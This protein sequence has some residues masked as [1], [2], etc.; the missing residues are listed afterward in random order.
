MRF[1]DVISLVVSVSIPLNDAMPDFSLLISTCRD[2]CPYFRD[3]ATVA[4]ESTVYQGATEGIC[5]TE[6]E[7]ASGKKK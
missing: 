5:V 6:L 1:P 4:F 3:E 2:L 7:R